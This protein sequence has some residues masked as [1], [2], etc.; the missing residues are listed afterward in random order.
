MTRS[1][2][3]VLDQCVA[4]LLAGSADIDTLVAQFP[5]EAGELRALLETAARLRSDGVEPLPEP[6]WVEDGWRRLAAA[7]RERK[8]APVGLRDRV[9]ALAG[10]LLPRNWSGRARAA[11]VVGTVG[12][13]GASGFAAA[14]G[15]MPDVAPFRFFASSG[16]SVTPVPQVE[17]EGAVVSVEDNVIVVDVNGGRERVALDSRTEIKDPANNDAAVALVTPG[18]RVKVEGVRQPD[19]SLLAREIKVLSVPPSGAPPQMPPPSSPVQVP[20]A[21]GRDCDPSGP[22]NPCKGEDRRGPGPNAGPGTTDDREFEDADEGDDDAAQATPTRTP[23]PDDDDEAEDDEPDQSGSKGPGSSDNIEAH[24][25]RE[26]S[27][28]SGSDDGDDDRNDGHEEES[29]RD[30]RGRGREPDA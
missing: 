3:D 27:R 30:E 7:I 6:A 29:R 11:V 2:D 20:P 28:G 12:L 4:D 21:F 24:D 22:G 16:S 25:D 9:T 5:A 18:V 17:F 13:V 10:W 26:G 1:F 15:G 14:A 23:R 8:N 19:G